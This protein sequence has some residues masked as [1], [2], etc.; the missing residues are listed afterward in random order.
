[1]G[2]NINGGLPSVI[3]LLNELHKRLNNPYTNALYTI[4]NL[5]KNKVG[6]MLKKD[7]KQE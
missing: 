4:I 2:S 1:M 7:F 6:I 5:N 3:Y